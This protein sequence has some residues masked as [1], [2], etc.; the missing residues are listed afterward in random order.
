M[1]FPA[2]LLNPVFVDPFNE[3]Q[4]FAREHPEVITAGLLARPAE[5]AAE[6]LAYSPADWLRFRKGALSVLLDISTT[7]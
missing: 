2:H 5:S 1:E 6:L 7:P 3:G 4:Q